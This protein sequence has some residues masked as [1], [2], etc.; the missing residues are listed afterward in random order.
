MEVWR[1]GCWNGHR[2]DCQT[3]NPFRAFSGNSIVT[4]CQVPPEPQENNKPCPAV[5][6]ATFTTGNTAPPWSQPV[7]SWWRNDNMILLRLQINAFF[8]LLFFESV[9]SQKSVGQDIRASKPR[10][11]MTEEMTRYVSIISGFVVSL[12]IQLW[13]AR[14]LLRHTSKVKGEGRRGPTMRSDE[15]ILYTWWIAT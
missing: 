14:S 6:M 11:E 8:K 3:S 9:A 1:K 10:I 15:L 2:W 5:D 4:P 13:S 12:P 7:Y